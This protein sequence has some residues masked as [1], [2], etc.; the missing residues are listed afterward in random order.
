M[1]DFHQNVVPTFTRLEGEDLARMEK[2]ILRTARRAPSGG[3]APECIDRF[4]RLTVYSDMPAKRRSKVAAV[5]TIRFVCALL[6]HRF[7]ITKREAP[8]NAAVA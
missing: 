7:K 1:A 5:P 6:D 3:L 8:Q 4:R 2:S